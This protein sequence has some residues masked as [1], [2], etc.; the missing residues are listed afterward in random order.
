M[1]R[2]LLLVI[3]L[4]AAAVP[5]LAS[6]P[7]SEETALPGWLIYVLLSTLTLIIVLELLIQFF[8]DGEENEHEGG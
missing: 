7:A 8:W 2:R 3:L 6:G 5:W 1:Q 4:L